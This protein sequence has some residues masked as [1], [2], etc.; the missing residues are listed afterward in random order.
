MYDF[1]PEKFADG[2]VRAATA[3]IAVRAKSKSNWDLLML[4]ALIMNSNKRLPQ[5]S[6]R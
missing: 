6:S 1:G 2:L 4:R 3:A 5:L